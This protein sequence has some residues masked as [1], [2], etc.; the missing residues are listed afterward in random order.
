[1]TLEM[2]EGLTDDAQEQV[3]ID[4]V[5]NVKSSPVSKY[6]VHLAYGD[7]TLIVAMIEDYIKG[8]DSIK[9]GDIQWE[10]YYRNKFKSISDK[11][12]DQ[13]EYD[14]EA[15]L[16]KCMKA[17]EK[18]SDVGEDALVLAIKKAPKIRKDDPEKDIVK[19]KQDKAAGQLEGQMNL[20]D[21]LA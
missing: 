8:L 14:Y 7:L 11:I 18:N 12:Q 21:F 2:M 1:M 4:G 10:C 16:K 9:D 19:E 15:K 13:I 3:E 5:L 6:K 20:D 17:K